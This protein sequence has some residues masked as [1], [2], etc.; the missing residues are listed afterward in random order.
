MNGFGDGWMAGPVL[1]PLLGSLVVSL[2]ITPLV[3]RIAR[4][5]EWVA[6]PSEDRWHEEAT[7]LSG[8]VAIYIAATLALAVTPGISFPWMLWG[9][10]T[11]L[12]VGGFVDDRIQIH[13]VVKLV[14]QIV[15]A[16]VLV[17]EGYRFGADWSV[18]ISVPLTFVW[19][20]GITNAVNLLDNMDGLAAGIS[21]IAAGVLAFFGVVFGYPSAAAT[22]L[23]IVGT[24]GGFLWYNFNPA[25]IFMGD[26]GSLF[27]GYLVAALGLVMQSFV[28]SSGVLVVLLVPAAVMAVP[29]FDTT[30]VTINRLLAG[31]PVSQGGRDHSSHRLVYLGLSEKSAVLS[32]Y[33]VSLI[34][35]SLAVV[36]HLA[37][38]RVFYAVAAYMG[39]GLAV[40][41]RFLMYIDVY[42]SDGSQWKTH[43][44]PA[45]GAE[46]VALRAVLRHKKK[47]AG[48]AADA[49]LVMASLMLA[50]LLRFEN[51]I[52]SSHL[53]IL[54]MYSPLVIVPKLLIFYAAGLYH[55]IWR[56]AGTPEL[57][58][59]AAATLMASVATYVL[60]VVVVPFDVS[61]AV[62]AIDWMMTFLTVGGARFAYRGLRQYV[63]AMRAHGRPT[64][65][66]GAGDMG[67]LSLQL[68]RQTPAL[69]LQPVGF[70]DD[71]TEKHGRFVQ[72]LRV[73]GSSDDLPEIC[74]TTDVEE[75]LITTDKLPPERLEAF[76]QTCT[77]LEISCR[78]FELS[79]QLADAD[80][81]HQNL[82][83]P[84]LS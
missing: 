45:D 43:I 82:R 40:V 73:L 17:L 58:R 24:A 72:G 75:I 52:P 49:I 84:V 81:T 36:F 46:G 23:V 62:F 69:E 68:I 63:G 18:W 33:G 28:P 80:S 7:A 30:L 21:A 74:E 54:E 8:G 26:C 1:V 32:L 65:L 19:I 55:G 37:D 78:E 9:G 59:L 79:F 38:V 12:F 15:A 67:A 3:I 2:L 39:V 53:L 29:I 42:N 4:K 47:L 6:E 22:A 20:I 31:R 61:E 51:G 44:L 27:L 25:S 70:I 83:E 16:G 5:L 66:Y 48:I 10:A 14:L 11:L 34:F 50:V 57:V 76:L 64:L 13:P 77:A 35:G 41:G 60:M 71:D 56:N